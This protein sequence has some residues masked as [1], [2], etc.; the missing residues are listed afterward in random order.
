MAV[1]REN[2]KSRF[3]R[4]FVRR[5]LRVNLPQRGTYQNKGSIQQFIDD[6]LT[7][8]EEYNCYCKPRKTEEDW[9]S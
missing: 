5:M 8:A 3:C 4:E 1:M 9:C 6:L 7:A 2:V